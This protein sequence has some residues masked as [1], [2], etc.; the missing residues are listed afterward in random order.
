MWRPPKRS[1]RRKAEKEGT[2]EL[3]AEKKAH[4]RAVTVLKKQCQEKIQRRESSHCHEMKQLHMELD[5]VRSSLKQK[6]LQQAELAWSL[7]QHKDE[8]EAAEQLEVQGAIGI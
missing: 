7:A 4:R 2:K 8:L 3:E 5:L 6:E 1:T